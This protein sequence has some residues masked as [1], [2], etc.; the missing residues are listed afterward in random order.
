MLQD[1]ASKCKDEQAASK[2]HQLSVAILESTCQTH[3]NTYH[4]L[5]SLAKLSP[6]ILILEERKRGSRRPKLFLIFG[7]YFGVPF[8]RPS[9]AALFQGHRLRL[10]MCRHVIAKKSTLIISCHIISYQRIHPSIYL[11]LDMLQLYILDSIHSTFVRS[12]RACLTEYPTE[13]L[14]RCSGPSGFRLCCDYSKQAVVRDGEGK[15]S[16]LGAVA[17][18][19][20]WRGTG[21]SRVRREIERE[22][23]GEGRGTKRT[24]FI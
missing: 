11:C 18:V 6:H 13:S 1:S 7:A 20:D 23:R 14:C 19:W 12:F 2:S 22:R 16:L 8:E 24:N 21:P 15:V 4:L 3:I 17:M 9:Q 10:S 5:E